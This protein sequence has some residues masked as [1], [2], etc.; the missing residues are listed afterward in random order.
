MI[1]LNFDRHYL[2]WATLLLRSLELHER[3][4]RVFCDTVGL[5]AGHL[6]ELLRAYPDVI[7]Q[8]VPASGQVTPSQMANRKAF[9]LR[10]AID[11]HVDE[12]WF[13]LLDADMLVRNR[14]DSL[15]RLIDNVPAALILTDG[16][17][18]GQFFARLVTV[19][20]IVLVRRDGRDVIDRWAHWH[21]HNRPVDAIQPGAW[22]W[23]Q[24]TLFLAWTEKGQ[25]IAP[26]SLPMFANDR[27]DPDAA[28]WAANV[29]DKE[30]YFHRFQVEYLR[31]RALKNG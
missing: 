31:Q 24:V 15:W 10:D 23:D 6:E 14:L 19:S 16:F 3:G 26:I 1:V 13:C 18:E 25:D 12:P 4:H 2:R 21:G 17:W 5:D 27:L 22:F 7:C 11:R 9:V 20:S 8:N 30:D 28:V 29:V